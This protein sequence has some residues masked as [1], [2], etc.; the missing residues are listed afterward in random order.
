MNTEI[1]MKNKTKKFSWSLDISTTNIGMA[2]W[3]ENGVLVELNHLQLSID[4]DIPE[5][6]RDIHKADLFKKYCYSFNDRIKEEYYAELENIFVEAPLS[7]TPKNINTTALLLGFNGMARYVLYSVFNIMPLKIGIYQSR[8]IFNPEFVKTK[9]VKGEIV[10]VLSFP[11]G[12]ASKEK[13]EYLRVKV[14]HLEPNVTW[15]YTRNGTIKPTSYDMSDA[16]VVGISGLI[17]MDVISYDDWYKMH[18]AIIE[19]I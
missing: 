6:D 1:R 3:D 19:N 14:S 4:R 16:Y 17:A 5:E 15:K 2:L 12:W 11:S 13:K 8:K 18:E 7:N 10:Q 9:K